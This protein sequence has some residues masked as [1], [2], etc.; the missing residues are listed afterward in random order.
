[1]VD[2]F[3]KSFKEKSDSEQENSSNILIRGRAFDQSKPQTFNQVSEDK[4]DV[5]LN[6]LNSTMSYNKYFSYGL[7]KNKND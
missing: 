1:M 7:A 2:S 6:I 4:I 3:F 5:I